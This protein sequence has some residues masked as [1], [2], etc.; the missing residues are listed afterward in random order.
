MKDCSI[1]LVGVGGQ[2]ILL[3]SDV[4]VRTAMLA[5]LDA[6]KVE[7]HGMSQRGGSVTS[8]V[9]FGLRVASPIIP[10]GASDILVSFDRLEALRHRPLLKADG[11]ALVNDADIVPTTVSSGMQPPVADIAGLLKA[12]FPR[13]I[14]FD[15]QALAVEAGNP[16]CANVVITGALSRLLEFDASLWLDALRSRVPPKLLDVNLRAFELG[17]SAQPAEA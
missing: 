1:S 2:G 10:Q 8:Q 13:L 9:R 11:V 4:L 7:V 15:A 17:R 14:C 16:K 3:S 12:T 6:K 5:G